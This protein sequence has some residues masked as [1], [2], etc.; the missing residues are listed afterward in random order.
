M[1]KIDAIV[2]TN[3]SEKEVAALALALQE[4]RGREKDFAELVAQEISLLIERKKPCF[5]QSV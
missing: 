1:R 3:T 2:I 5:F 4:Q